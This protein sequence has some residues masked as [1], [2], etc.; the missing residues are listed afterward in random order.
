MLYFAYG[1]NMDPDQMAARC[2]SSVAHGIGYLADHVLCFPRQSISRACGVASVRAEAGQHTWG[3]V[4]RMTMEDFTRLDT[5]EDFVPDRAAHLN[6][7][8]RETRHVHI[9]DS[10]VETHIYIANIEDA[11]PPPSLAYLTHMRIGARHHGLP[12]EYVAMLEAL[13]HG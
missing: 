2:P 13:E 9:D 12:A 7:Y 4:Y 11:P 10:P 5:F 8:M 3:V 1:S 6:G